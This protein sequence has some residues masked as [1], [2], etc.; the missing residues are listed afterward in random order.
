MKNESKLTRQWRTISLDMILIVYYDYNALRLL[1]V[2]ML[3]MIKN[4]GLRCMVLLIRPIWKNSSQS[5]EGKVY[6]IANVKFM[7]TA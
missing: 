7:T 5:S 4:T 3:M 2:Y 1:E 6:V